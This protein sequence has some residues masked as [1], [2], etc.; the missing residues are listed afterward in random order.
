MD[1]AMLPP[2]SLARGCPVLVFCSPYGNILY[3]HGSEV[4]A[5][6]C[7]VGDLGSIPGLG[8]S[9]GEGNG[10]PLQYS[11]LENLM[12]GGAWW[13]TVHG[14]AKSRTWL[15][16]FTHTHIGPNDDPFQEDLFQLASTSRNA[17][18]S[19]PD[20]MAGHCWPTPPPETPRHSQASLDQSLMGSLL[21]SPGPWCLQD[22]VCVLW[23]SVSP[24]LWKFLNQ[25][26]L[27]FKARFPSDSQALF[28]ISRLESLLWGLEP[29]G[30]IV[31]QFVNHPPGS[32]MVW[33]IA[34]SSKTILTTLHGSQDC[35]C[36]C[37][38]PRSGHCWPITLQ[39]TLKHSG[40][41]GSVSCGDHHSFPWV[42]IYTSFRLC[43]PR[44]WSLRFAFKCNLNVFAPLFL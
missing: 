20:P 33:L 3:S 38:C 36:Q 27:T 12:D 11:C 1:G 18:A 5:S 19:A 23:V 26:S 4:K 41:S 34:M 22:F 39:E 30:I 10:N 25:I 28:W 44:V 35:C 16:D 21:L 13:A 29:S 24:H 17:A 43:P 2:C 37:P 6:A 9:P 32:S 8:R 14:V 15:S 7:N 31:L 42:L 40:R